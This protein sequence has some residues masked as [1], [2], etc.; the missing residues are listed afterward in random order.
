MTDSLRPRHGRR[1]GP[2]RR[3]LAALSRFRHTRRGKWVLIGLACL[4]TLMVGLLAAGFTSSPA[5]RVTA[6]PAATGGLGAVPADPD[7]SAR[8]RTSTLRRH[9]SATD[10]MQI[11]KNKFPDNPL[12]HLRANGLH[13]VEISVRSSE[14]VA[15]VGYLVPTGLGSSYGTVKPKARRW[16]MRE[17][18]L[19]PG[20]L[21]AVFVQSGKSGAPVTCSV[22]VDGKAT[23]SETTNGS[24]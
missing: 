14:P 18:A 6:L 4:A 7:V 9:A 15:L 16:A 12:N 10:P 23:N 19:G 2:P 17:Q 21:A 3:P 5:K 1:P 11:L 8:A 20:Y 24:Y 13:R 22:S